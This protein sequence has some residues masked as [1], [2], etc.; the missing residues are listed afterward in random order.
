M[1]DISKQQGTYHSGDVGGIVQGHDSLQVLR[2]VRTPG[3]KTLGI[4]HVLQRMRGSNVVH[5]GQTVACEG[6]S[7]GT[8]APNTD[9]CKF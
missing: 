6:L 9:T 7:V 1:N 2:Q 3:G 5:V 8:N 4:S